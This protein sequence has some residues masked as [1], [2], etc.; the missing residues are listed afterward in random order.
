MLTDHSTDRHAADAETRDVHVQGLR[1][2]YRAIGSGRPLLLANRMRG[3][4]DT[5]DPLFIDSLAQSHTVVLFDYPGVGY[6]DGRLPTTMQSAAG[7]VGAFADALGIGTWAMGGW[8]WGGMVAQAV[9]LE[10]PERVTH[11]LLIATNPPGALEHRIQ[12]RFLE[13][14]LKPVND[15]ADEEVLFFEPASPRSLTAARISRERIYARPGVVE[16]IPSTQEA[17][18]QYLAAAQEFHEGG[19]ALRE[20]LMQSATPILILGGD[21][22]P[23][24]AVQNWFPLVGKIPL[25]QL[26][27]LPEAGHAPQHQYPELVA[28]YIREFLARSAG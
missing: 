15:L 7:F 8:S 25:G 12:P 28:A 20:R 9:L 2:A 24:T 13:R 6:S 3:T 16:R 11:G 27:V 4:L 14:A 18:M 5:W 19:A 1:I 23:S 21:N 26:I 22:D 10:S 17:I